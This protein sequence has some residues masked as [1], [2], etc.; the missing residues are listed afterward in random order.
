MTL[1]IYGPGGFGRELASFARYSRDV[2][3]ISDSDSEVGSCINGI[4]VHSLTS[5]QDL[6]KLEVVIAVADAQIRRRLVQK[7]EDHKIKF[8]TFTAPH[9]LRGDNITEGEGAA[10][11]S[12]TIITSDV[13]IGKHFH[14][15]IYS[16][17]AH[18]CIIGD[19]VTLAPR[20]CVNG[21]T[22]VEDDVYIGTGAVLKQGTPDRPLRIGHGAVIGMG[23][24]VTRDVEPGAVVVGSPAR[25]LQK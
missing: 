16:F 6:P 13:I 4:N 1:A 5:A 20:V 11:C 25:P 19:F 8:A 24:V 9:H 22:I 23:A 7:C 2:I 12:F 3:F 15:N 14:C 18:D 21:N 17:V 10:Y